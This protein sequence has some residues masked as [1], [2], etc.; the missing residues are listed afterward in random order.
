MVRETAQRVKDG[1]DLVLKEAERIEAS[2][3]AWDRRPQLVDIYGHGHNGPEVS[4][5]HNYRPHG[6]NG[7]QRGLDEC[8][9]RFTFVHVL[10]VVSQCLFLH[11][12][13]IL[14][15]DKVLVPVYHPLSLRHQL[16]ALVCR[17]TDGYYA[18]E[19]RLTQGLV[20]PCAIRL[21]S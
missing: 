21:G 20:L 4:V 13:F 15:N 10:D 16:L 7:T 17:R 18:H 5:F 14:A 12:A 2:D 8:L 9:C 6:S 3:E 1:L 19:G 11:E